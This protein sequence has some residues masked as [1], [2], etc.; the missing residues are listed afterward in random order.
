M[1]PPPPPPE[2]ERPPPNP[3]KQP[4]KTIKCVRKVPN[5]KLPPPRVVIASKEKEIERFIKLFWKVG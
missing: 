3:G 2:G 4:P 5:I 1:A